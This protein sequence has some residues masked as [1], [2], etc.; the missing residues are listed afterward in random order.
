MFNILALHLVI[1]PQRQA[2]LDFVSDETHLANRQILLIF[3]FFLVLNVKNS[4]QFFLIIDSWLLH[5]YKSKRK[6]Q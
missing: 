4:R 3:F 1:I 6:L 5:S 2:L